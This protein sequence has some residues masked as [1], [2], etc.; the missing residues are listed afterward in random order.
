MEKQCKTYPIFFPLLYL[1]P[2]PWVWTVCNLPLRCQI[3]SNIAI[4]ALKPSIA[5]THPK[6]DVNLISCY[7][8]KPQ[9]VEP[10]VKLSIDTEKSFQYSDDLGWNWHKSWNIPTISLAFDV[11]YPVLAQ[12][13]CSNRSLTQILKK[14]FYARLILK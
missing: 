10:N 5:L 4:W 8:L 1:V 14:N 3:G 2:T 6:S 11:T 12:I 7:K 13:Y 9:D